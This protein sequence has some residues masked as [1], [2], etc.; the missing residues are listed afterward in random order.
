MIL[1]EEKTVSKLQQKV[2]WIQLV[3]S[4]ESMEDH[5]YRKTSESIL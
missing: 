2:I 5:P 1:K 3:K 4:E